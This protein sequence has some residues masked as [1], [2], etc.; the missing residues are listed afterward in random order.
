L[1][2]ASLAYFRPRGGA[3]AGGGGGGAV[4]ASLVCAHYGRLSADRP[5][6]VSLADLR[7]SLSTLVARGVECFDL[8]LSPLSPL[9]D[10]DG[11]TAVAHP[12]ALAAAGGAAA[13]A[14]TAADLAALLAEPAFARARVTLELKGALARGG[15]GARALARALAAAGPAVAARVAVL[16]AAPGV[17]LPGGLRRAASVRDADAPRCSDAAL[18]DADAALDADAGGSAGGVRVVLPSAA[19]WRDDDARARVLAWAA[20][21]AAA[22]GA[23]PPDVHVWHGDDQAAA[24]ELL[25]LGATRVIS[26]APLRLVGAGDG[27]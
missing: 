5:P 17:R 6:P 18:R 11:G 19:C 27:E 12:A 20:A 1:L 8:D 9:G 25:R 14:A 22:R 23:A 10:D 7:S 21:A 24:A 3:G 4:P 16:G 26:N 15:A 13:G 2:V